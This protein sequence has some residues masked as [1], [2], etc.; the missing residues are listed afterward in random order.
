MFSVLPVNPRRGP[1]GDEIGGVSH[2]VSV[3]PVRVYLVLEQLETK[4]LFSED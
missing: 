4:Q 3:S 2:S 1:S